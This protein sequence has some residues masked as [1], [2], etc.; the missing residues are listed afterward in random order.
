M[1]TLL[2]VT[3]AAAV[4][5]SAALPVNAATE[6]RYQTAQGGVVCKPTNP[7]TTG[8]VAKA[9]GLRNEG[10]ATTTVICGFESSN[11]RSDFGTIQ[12]ITMG[13]YGLNGAAKTVSCTAVNGFASGSPIYATKNVTTDAGGAA[14]ILNY[15]ASDFGGTAGDPLP[16]SDYW[17]ITCNLPGN[18]SIGFMRTQFTVNTPA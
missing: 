4:L 14:T 7:G 2:G 8:V 17:S 15:D 6:I 12:S 9:T 16:A 1:R 18:T 10:T 3:I 13:V 11:S 5:A